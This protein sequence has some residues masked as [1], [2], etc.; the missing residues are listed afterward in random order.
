MVSR[1]EAARILS[2]SVPEVDRLR[3]SGRLM[4]KKHGSRVLFP[5]FELERFVD[6]LPWE[7]DL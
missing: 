4:A 1:N 5:L 2:L 6:S 3:Y 7:V